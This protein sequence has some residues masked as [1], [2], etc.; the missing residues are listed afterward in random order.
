SESP[1]EFR[2]E[3]EINSSLLPQGP[4]NKVR[5]RGA[6]R[7]KQAPD[8]GIALVEIAGDFELPRYGALALPPGK[9]SLTL[10]DTEK[11]EDYRARWELGTGGTLE[12]AGGFDEARTLLTGK[13]TAKLESALVASLAGGKLPEAV[14][15]GVTDVT[16][17]AKSGDLDVALTGDLTAKDWGRVAPQLAALEPFAGTLKA[18]LTRRGGRLSV[19]DSEA[20]LRSEKGAELRL[21]QAQPVDPLALPTTPVATLKLEKLPLTWANPWLAASDIA[22]DPATL[23]GAWQIALSPGRDEVRLTPSQPLSLGPLRVTGPRLPSMLPLA[24]ALSPRIAVSK[25]RIGL[26][27]DDLRVTTERGDRVEARFTATCDSAAKVALAGELTGQVPT[28][29]SGPERPLPFALAAKW[30]LALVGSELR[31]TVLEITACPAPTA[32]PNFSLE[33]L[34]P[35][36]LDLKKLAVPPATA[37]TDWARLRFSG[38]P[39][40]WLSRWAPGREIAGTVAAGESMLRSTPEGMLSFATTEPWTVNDAAVIVGGKT[41]FTGMARIAPDFSVHDGRYTAAVREIAAVEKNGSRIHGS[42]TA[43]ATLGD[44]RAKTTIALD[45]ELPALPHAKET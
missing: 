39:L 7:L 4:E 22:L 42:I 16:F 18:A 43:E 10:A 32:A 11:G 44:R 19:H 5:S 38:L 23:Q 8:N 6:I 9:F 41:F 14:A 20:V 35:I 36:A 2:Y 45:A 12:F 17:D 40:G 37:R 26:E 13:A 27:V 21:A 3:L 33:L 1:G 15:T 31:A 30:D 25:A 28:L 29:L 34:R 24:I